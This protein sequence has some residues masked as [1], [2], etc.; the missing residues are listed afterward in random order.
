MKDKKEKWEIQYED[1]QNGGLDKKI[2][3]LKAK[4]ENKE[5]DAKQYMKEQKQIDKI[6]TNLPKVE[7]LLELR[8]ELKDLKVEIEEELVARE[9]EKSKNENGNKLED[10]MQKLDEENAK[11][12]IS[13]EET[14]KQLK[15][16]NLSEQDKKELE[17]K[18][19]K[20]N[21][22]LNENNSKFMELNGKRKAYVAESRDTEISKMNDQDLKKNYQKICMKLSRNN[23]YAKRLLKGYDI[24]SVKA[25]DKKID[26][27][28]KKYDIDM[29]KLTAK[30]KEAE[31]IKGLRETAKEEKSIEKDEDKEMDKIQNELGKNVAEIIKENQ[32][33][34]NLEMIEVDEFAQKHPRLAK[35]KQFFSNIKNKVVNKFG[36]A[37]EV[38]NNEQVL[39]EQNA[40]DEKIDSKEDKEKIESNNNKHRSFVKRLKDMNEYEIFDVA[41]KGMDGIRNEK[42]TE[43]NKKLQ[44]NKEKHANGME[45]DEK[46]YWDEKLK[47]IDN[48]DAR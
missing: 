22:D 11:L 30:G 43:A 41:E 39:E 48:N 35:I 40:I 29:K 21:M 47:S 15:N 24:E 32:S 13:I 2:E 7:H 18:L 4:Y 27:N 37:E 45:A 36:K 10:E 1:Y 8:N 3:E 31:K 14:Q 16:P 44:K 46:K 9:N 42:I 19:N 33:N 38:K 20:D 12:L 17:A 6:K 5:I 25:E 23:F 34:K 28:S 26:W